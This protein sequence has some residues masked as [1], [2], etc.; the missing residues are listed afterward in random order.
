M[1]WV[2]TGGC[3]FV[4]TNLIRFLI[5]NGN[6]SIRVVDNL[7][8]GTRR[9][10]AEVTEFVECSKPDYPWSEGTVQSRE[11]SLQLIV[12]DIK[13]IALANKVVDGAD[14]II[15]LAANTGVGPSI[16]DPVSDCHS[17]VVG[18][19]NYLEAAR[20]N[21]IGRFVFASSGAPI[22]VIEPPIHE[23]ICPRPISPYGASKL[24]GEAYCSAYW[25]SFG[26]ETV[27]L[28]F[29]NVYGPGSTHKSSVVA[30]F[31]KDALNGRGLDIH[32]DG[33]QT[34][35]FI[36]IEDLVRAV[37]KAT[38]SPDIGG[39]LFQIAA[40][41]ETTIAK[42]AER[43]LTLLEK[44]GTANIPIRYSE[45]RPG[46]VKRNYSDISK[47]KK[48]LDWEPLYT[49]EAGLDQTIEYFMEL[50]FPGS[51]CE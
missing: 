7:S 36:Y 44:R 47:A 15:H 8:V 26:I 2:I 37:Y 45:F 35:D 18:T 46:D 48:R 19:L 38:A 9:D 31:I 33:T 28:R 17:N 50:T 30:K 24:A 22:G 25:G 21:N 27:A 14:V 5:Q 49:L 51:D 42:L 43:I 20:S 32:G 6:H 13:D 10:L 1:R 40:N 12:G 39:E 3:G 34:R 29:G 4:G 41:T 11:S 23:N 16:S